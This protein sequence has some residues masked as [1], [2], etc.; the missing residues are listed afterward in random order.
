M[1]PQM[2]AF[3][4]IE[5]LISLAIA[6]LLAAMTIPSYQHYILQARRVEGQTALLDA[7]NRMERYYSQ[8]HS[9]Q[10]STLSLLGLTASTTNGYYTLSLSQL[11]DT[12]YLIEASPN[13]TQKDDT[14]G[15]L[16]I[17]QLG[18]RLPDISGCW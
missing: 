6:A 13:A 18:Q 1:R 14:C 15:T 3:S 2:Q 11:S 4:L 17:N 9:Y 8:T 5:L 7:A 12:S 10:D 16:A